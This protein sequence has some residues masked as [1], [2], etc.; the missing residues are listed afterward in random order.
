[1]NK[2]VIAICALTSIVRLEWCL[3]FW[4]QYKPFGRDFHITAIANVVPVAAARN[5]ALQEAKEKGGKYCLFYDDDII[6]HRRDAIAV[7]VSALD[8]LPEATLIGSVC[9]IRAT[10]PEPIIIK[11]EG[12]GP[13]FGWQDG[14][15]HQVY[16]SGTGFL[17]IRMDDL[18]DI[19]VPTVVVEGKEVRQFFQQYEH[20]GDFLGTD[21]YFLA[22]VMKEHN[23][24]WLVHGSVM[25]D[26]IDRDGTRYEI[27][28]SIIRR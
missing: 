26:Q 23:K 19:D 13:W 25:C 4:A 18:E 3:E 12:E 22:K 9:P 7:L 5:L 17:L 21:D 10:V 16:H 8:Q 20:P 14:D 11:T 2:V 1:M 24:K 28:N 27:A 15:I 6:P